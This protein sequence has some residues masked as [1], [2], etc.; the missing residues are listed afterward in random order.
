MI[1][2]ISGYHFEN[3]TKI[4]VSKYVECYIKYFIIQLYVENND[5]I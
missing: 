2:F 4:T 3:F 5:E 1:I